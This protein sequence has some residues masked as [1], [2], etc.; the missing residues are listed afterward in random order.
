MLCHMPA[1]PFLYI[2]IRFVPPAAGSIPAN[3]Q[4]QERS[5]VTFIQCQTWHPTVGRRPFCRTLPAAQRTR[6]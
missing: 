4:Q 6:L 5:Q 3:T 2:I 1:R